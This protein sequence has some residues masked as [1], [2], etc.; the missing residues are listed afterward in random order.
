[1]F[2][3]VDSVFDKRCLAYVVLPF[4]EDGLILLQ[5]LLSLS[6][7]LFG[8]PIRQTIHHS[9]NYVYSLFRLGCSLT[10]FFQFDYFSARQLSKPCTF[11]QHLFSVI[12]IHFSNVQLQK[13]SRKALRLLCRRPKRGILK[14]SASASESPV[15]LMFRLSRSGTIISCFGSRTTSFLVQSR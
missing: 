4:G 8:Q 9:L 13:L 2:T 14:P 15:F 3:A 7:L 5:K 6:P 10:A 11:L 12:R 1:M